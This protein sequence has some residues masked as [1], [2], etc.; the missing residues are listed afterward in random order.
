MPVSIFAST[1]RKKKSEREKK[2]EPTFPNFGRGMFF[3]RIPF[4]VGACF[5]ENLR[6]DK[7]WTKWIKWRFNAVV[8]SVI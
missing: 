5:A 3:V 7:F 8:K 1:Q 6:T 2:K 4:W